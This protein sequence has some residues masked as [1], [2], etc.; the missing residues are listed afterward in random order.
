[1]SIAHIIKR[2]TKLLFNSHYLADKACRKCF[3][4]LKGWPKLD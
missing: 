1:M 4:N 2:Y 3:A